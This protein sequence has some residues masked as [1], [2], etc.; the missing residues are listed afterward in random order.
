MPGPLVWILALV[1]AVSTHHGTSGPQTARTAT[2]AQRGAS[3]AAPA[4][5]IEELTKLLDAGQLAPA[6]ARADEALRRFPED[7]PLLNIAGAIDAQQGAYRSAERHFRAAILADRRIAAAYLNL[8]RL[9]QEHAK[10]DPQAPSKALA[11]YRQLLEVDPTDSEALFQAAYMSACTGEWNASRALLDRLPAPARS[12]P[13]VL[14]LFA[15]DFVGLGD[16]PRA[17]HMATELLT[18]PDLA[19]EDVR[20]AIPAL[21]RLKDDSL[22]ER[23]FTG[24]DAR[25]LASAE[26]LRQL[27]LVES[28]R[29]RFDRARATLER[30]MVLAG[31]PTV[32]VLLDLAQVAYKEKDFT[33]ALGYLAH[34]R[35]L[36][37][38]NPQVH[39]FFGIACIELNLGNEAYEALKKAV[40]L[41]PENAY[42]NYAMGAVAIHRHESSEALPYFEKYVRLKPD[43]PRGRF[44]LGAARF[45]SNEFD[46]A[47]TELEQAARHPETAAG[48]HYFLARISRQLNELDTARREIGRSLQAD[49][50]YP[51]ALA[52]LGLLQTRSGDYEAA[53]R[54]LTKALASDPE[55]YAATVNL[56]A[57]YARTRDPRREGQ[58]ARLADL[59][60]KRAVAAQE[61]LRMI[62]VVQ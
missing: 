29:G 4:Q 22:A 39:F 60:Q 20:A 32:T 24:L 23:L 18:H 25:N 8:G 54:S 1:F 61:F 14:A 59:Q 43:D 47:R 58:A 15:V 13:Q 38:Q 44:A 21:D 26:S 34:A 12:R 40:T 53:E 33:G 52:E 46:L 42:V 28:R 2:R 51:D 37:P 35:D 30:A 31:K 45:Y 10:E 16:R 6:K 9:Y 7:A 5:L 19:D 50:N 17:D 48:A 3:S 57:L 56:A 11:V 27:A 49:P 36:D 55:N 62:Q 41:A